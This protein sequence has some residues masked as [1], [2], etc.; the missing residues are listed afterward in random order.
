M[1]KLGS[2]FWWSF[3]IFC[4]LT[5]VFENLWVVMYILIGSILF[6]LTVISYYVDDPKQVKRLLPDDYVVLKQ[7]PKRQHGY[8]PER[9]SDLIYRLLEEDDIKLSNDEYFMLTHTTSTLLDILHEIQKEIGIPN[10]SDLEF[11]EKG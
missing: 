9:F 3:V 7:K 1:N 4:V 5:G 6:G 11:I 10:H 2:F 8:P